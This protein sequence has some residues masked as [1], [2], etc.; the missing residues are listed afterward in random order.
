MQDT[1][2]VIRLKKEST[3]VSHS[4]TKEVSEQTTCVVV[5]NASDSFY[6]KGWFNYK[7]F[8]SKDGI[9]WERTD[10]G[11]FDG[12]SFSFNVN[13]ADRFISWYVPYAKEN[14]DN[15]LSKVNLDII[16]AE[17]GSTK[18]GLPYI[19]IGDT[20]KDCLVLMARQHPGETMSSFFLDGVIKYLSSLNKESFKK[21]SFL[22]I[23][24]VNLEGVEN[25]THRYDCLG[26]DYNR[27]R[28]KSHLVIEQVLALIKSV[29]CSMVL[30]IHGDEVSKNNYIMYEGKLSDNAKSYLSAFAKC[31][32]LVLKAQSFFKRFVKNIIRNKKIIFPKGKSSARQYLTSLNINS[33]TIEISAHKSDHLESERLG[34]DFMRLVIQK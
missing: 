27:S 23:P 31:D 5:E 24:F 28:N 25:S 1:K 9:N 14:F 12:K 6:A 8:S 15:L 18:A 4:F 33:L 20:S 13:K 11:I 21:K 30:D 32:F 2:T 10:T 3:T 7:P 29:N 16:G 17:I 26:V 19:S 34:Y 22:I